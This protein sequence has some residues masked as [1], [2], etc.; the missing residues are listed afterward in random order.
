MKKTFLAG[1]ATLLPITITI[2]VVVFCVDLLTAPFAGIVEDIITEHG[3]FELGEKH[4][5]LLIILS[6]IVVL[7]FFFFLILILGF[8][9]RKIAF[10]WFINFA[11]RVFYK[12]P[13]IKTIYKLSREVST[14][15][16]SEKKEKI[17]KGTVS[18]PFPHEKT[19][20][21]GLLS[22]P[23]PKEVRGKDQ[24]LQS[25]FIPTAPHPI[26]GFL[27]MYN[28][29]EIKSVDMKTEDLFKFLLSCGIYH[30]GAENN[31]S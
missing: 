31:E 23:P 18:V 28:E 15:V 5:Y 27:V 16:F 3:A 4:K 21:L 2:V 12:I 9:G 17:F 7:I 24:T 29:Q 11:H 10:S 8:L 22:G 25:V 26:S 19:R 1:L 13:I 30:P 20:A 14:S 6:R